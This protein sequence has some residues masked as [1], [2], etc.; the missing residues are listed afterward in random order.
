[1]ND[2]NESTDP[3]IIEQS[4]EDW[5]LTKVNDWGDYYE[6]NYADKHQEY[7]RLFIR[8]VLF[9]KEN[10]IMLDSLKLQQIHIY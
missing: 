7:Y 9:L 6:N 2:Y 5:V 3:I 8:L 1:M 10:K 4:L